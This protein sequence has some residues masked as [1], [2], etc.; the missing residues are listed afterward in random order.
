MVPMLLSLLLYFIFEVHAGCFSHVIQ[1]DLLIL[2]SQ[3]LFG[4]VF[5]PEDESRLLSKCCECLCSVIM[6]KVLVHISDV[7][8]VKP[9]SR[10][11]MVHLK[12]TV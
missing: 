3:L 12:E 4:L 2:V 6:E 9:L 11:Y 5:S 1:N 10:D 7:P 8:H